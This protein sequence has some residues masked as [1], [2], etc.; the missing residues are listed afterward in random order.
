MIIF[1]A[2]HLL[3]QFF[4]VPETTY[5]RDARREIDLGTEDKIE[6]LAAAV[7]EQGRLDEKVVASSAHMDPAPLD[8]AAEAPEK[9]TFRQNLAV[10]TGTY[11]NRNLLQ[12]YFAPWAVMTNIATALVVLIYSLSLVMFIVVAFII[13]QAFTKAPWH[14]KAGGLGRLSFGP[15]IGGTIA[16]LLNALLS[17]RLIRWCARRNRG[18]YEPEYRLI[19]AFLAF[20]TGACLMGWGVAVSDGLSQYACATL[21]GLILFG[22]VFTVSGVSGYAVDSY[23]NMTAEIFIACQTAKNFTSFGFSFFVNDW[24]AKVGVR[25]SF[26]A[27]GGLMFGLATIIPLMFIFGK[28]QRSFWARHSLMEKWHI[29][30]HQGVRGVRKFRDSWS[31]KGT[32]QLTH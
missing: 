8:S 23:R 14:L 6:D 15:F 12:L 25:H 3:L 13:P 16:C 4:L 27:W 29:L 17:D 2:I 5:V 1:G 11:S 9:K 18:V 22:I 19:P 31:W 20:V 21:H 24:T 32:E 28:K 10:Y 30:T 26:F 7:E